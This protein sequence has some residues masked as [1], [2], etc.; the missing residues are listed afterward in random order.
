M[1]IAIWHAIR[2]KT[3]LDETD[4]IGQNQKQTARKWRQDLFNGKSVEQ[5]GNYEFLELREIIK[6]KK[7][8]LG[9]I[10]GDD[11]ENVTTRAMQGMKSRVCRDPE[12]LT[13]VVEGA[14]TFA[15]TSGGDFRWEGYAVF[16]VNQW[17]WLPLWKE[18]CPLPPWAKESPFPATK[19]PWKPNLHPPLAPGAPLACPDDVDNCI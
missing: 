5:N 2:K 19:R 18:R 11:G 16:C 8:D 6:K 1:R 13:S 4:E 14:R 9:K 3:G 10:S 17:W 12:V 15:S 7:W